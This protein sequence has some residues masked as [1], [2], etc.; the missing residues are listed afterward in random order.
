MYI[1][2]FPIVWSMFG[3]SAIHAVECRCFSPPIIVWMLIGLETGAMFC[4]KAEKSTGCRVKQA[5]VASYIHGRIYCDV[6]L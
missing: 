1:V 5:R 6:Q 4:V 3:S 2:G